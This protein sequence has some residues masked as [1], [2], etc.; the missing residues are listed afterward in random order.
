[1]SET[2][3]TLHLSSP[4]DVIGTLLEPDADTNPDG[5]TW[6]RGHKVDYVKGH[7]TDPKGKVAYLV[8][9]TSRCQNQEP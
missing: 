2:S 9:R 5:S 3:I 6:S 8:R 1:M 4:S 7:C